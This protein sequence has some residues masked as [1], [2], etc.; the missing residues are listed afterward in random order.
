MVLLDYVVLAVYFVVLV[1]IGI[2]ASRKIKRQEDYFM[3]GRSFGK[4]LQTFAAFGAGTGSSDPVNTARTTF[5]SGMSGMW[6]VMYWLFVTPFYWITGVWYRRMRHLTLGDWFVERYE[7]QRLGVGYAIFGILFF[8]V[9]GSMFFSGIGKVAAPLIG[10]AEVTV[11]GATVP[12]EYLLVPSIGL[13]VLVYGMAG[14][15]EAAYYTDLIQGICIILLSLLLVPF[16]LSALVEKF[17]PEGG[18]W[19]L[20]FRIMHEQIPKEHFSVIG[21]T[22]SSEFPLH[23]IIAVV[24][25]NLV[26]IVVQPHFIAT[27]G[28]SAKDENSARIGLV[29]GNFLKRFCTIGWVLT[30]LIALALF[31]D[32]P[33]LINDPDKTWGVAS[34]ELLGPGLRGLML[35]CL[36]AALMSSVDAY[37]VVGS[38]LVVRNIYAPYINPQASERECINVGRLTGTFTVV[39]SIVIALSVN[40]MLQQLELTWV[41]PVLFAAP[42]W[43]GMFWRGATTAAAWVTVTFCAFMFFV[44]PFAAPRVMPSLRTMEQYQTINEIVETKTTRPAAPTDVAKRVGQMTAWKDAQA[45]AEA[46]VDPVQRAEA[47]QGLGAE[48]LP[49]EVGQSLTDTAKSGGKSVFWS[50]GVVPVSW[51]AT[52]ADVETRTRQ[53]ENWKREQAAAEAVT[54]ATWR[55]RLLDELGAQPVTLAVGDLVTTAATGEG[56]DA[57]GLKLP[58]PQPM[59]DPQPIGDQTT[60]VVMRYREDVKFTGKGNFRLEFL[61]YSLAGL[62]LT[63]SS[64]ATLSTLELPPK[65]IAPFLVMILCS[66]LTR[67]NS[68]AALDRY[69]AKM[70]TPVDPD[71]EKDRQRLEQY[72]ADPAALE[73]KKLFPGTSLEMQR[74]SWFDVIGFIVCFVICFGVIG[75]AV[76]VAQ[77]GT[78]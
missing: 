3:G 26:G 43:I 31:A 5:T 64:N 6:S 27:G 73:A 10:V 65:I 47:L 29:V 66:F 37:M 41:F 1:A 40:N 13:I 45:A 28:G 78:G 11:L 49:L 74:P 62:D 18:S 68:Q 69:Y 23:R 72:A 14:G 50:R 63:K 51:L 8:M 55:Q 60:R 75:V 15:L 30:A 77:I 54:D 32:H 70:K 4:L 48:P 61:V 7:S 39:G 16:G 17:A 38:A 9:Y 52:D 2:I 71:P 67:K 46:I 42:F 35:A 22:N 12:I 57:T 19:W 20:G 36:L 58:A 25:I 56:K 44:I 24:V 76:W 34:R 59:S 21:S 33:E 53:I